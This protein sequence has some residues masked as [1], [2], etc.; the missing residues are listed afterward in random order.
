M[1]RFETLPVNDGKMLGGHYAVEHEGRMI[2]RSFK[3]DK[4]QAEVLKY[5]LER[6]FELGRASK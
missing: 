6:A 4:V 5:E 1:S 2:G 3:L